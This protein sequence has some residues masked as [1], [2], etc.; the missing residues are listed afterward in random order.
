MV[1]SLFKSKGR[2]CVM[3]PTETEAALQRAFVRLRGFFK[4]SE[5]K[6]APSTGSVLHLAQRNEILYSLCN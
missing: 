1:F 4:A 5:Q 2:Q 6:E 3:G